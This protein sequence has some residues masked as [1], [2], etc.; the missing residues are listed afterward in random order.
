MP[1]SSPRVRETAE[2]QHQLL[3]GMSQLIEQLIALSR[4]SFSITPDMGRSVGRA[5]AAMNEAVEHLAT[6]NPR[7]A[8]RSQREGMAALNETAIALNNAMAAMQESGSASG[9]EQYLQR[10]QNLSQGQ[11]GLNEQALQMSLGQ[12]GAMSQIELMRRLQARQRQLARVLDQLLKDYPTQSGG[13]QGGLGEALKDMDE[14]VRDFQRRRVTRRTLDRQQE[15]LS[16]LLDNQKSLAVKDFKEER[17]GATPT[18]QFTY[19]GPAGLPTNLGERQ[20]LILQA[21]EQA[22]RTGY[23]QEY[24]VIIQNYFRQ[25][26][27]RT[28]QAE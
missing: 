5:R 13:K 11:Q 20:D 27:T 3:S 18:E 21:M 26:A 14:V 6:N 19:L 28:T 25:L 16:R 7:E 15:I 8:A 2:T 1:R 17:K 24:Q 23:S 9:F 10:M 4:Q 12:V 22:L